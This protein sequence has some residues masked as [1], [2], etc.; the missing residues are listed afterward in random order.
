VFLFPCV[1]GGFVVLL[2]L[3]D[4]FL[5]GHQVYY[6]SE[7]SVWKGCDFLV[8]FGPLVV[9]WLAGEMVGFVCYSWLVF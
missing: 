4:I 2:G 6:V 3:A 1:Q 9:V 5:Q 8:V 7:Q